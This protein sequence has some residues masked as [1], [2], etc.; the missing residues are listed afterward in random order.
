MA[1]A[2]AVKKEKVLSNN[3]SPFAAPVPGGALPRSAASAFWSGDTAADSSTQSP[4]KA[5]LEREV[6]DVVQ[7]YLNGSWDLLASLEDR[8][9]YVTTRFE[10]G[11]VIRS[12][13]VPRGVGKEVVQTLWGLGTAN[14]YS[15]VGWNAV[16][17]E[18]AME[19]NDVAK[20]TAPFRVKGRKSQ[21][22]QVFIMNDWY[23]CYCLC[24]WFN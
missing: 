13:D 1:A 14:L 24:H 16:R 4:P 22:F 9:P 8:L 12:V 20:S 21:T 15:R 6:S 7:K 3:P 10:T 17:C 11:T 19:G 2:A 5:I 23:N 18:V